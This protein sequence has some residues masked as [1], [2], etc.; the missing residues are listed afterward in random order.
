MKMKQPRW[1]VPVKLG[2][3]AGLCFVLLAACGGDSPEL[4][5]K[6]ARDYLAKDDSSAAVI[7]LR[8]ALQKAPNNAEARYLLGTA[9]AARRDPASAVKELRMAL[10]LGYP[11]EQTL[12]ALARALVDD[13]DAKELVAEFGGKTLGTP[14]AQADFKTI[15]GNAWLSLG[16]P[17]EAEAAFAAALAAKPD[18]PD[19]S[20]GI[21]TLRAASRNFEEADKIVDG[22][23]AQPKAP[24]EASLLKAELLFAEG[25]PDA[26]RAVLEKL[27]E[28]RPAY[29]PA[30]YRLA[31]LQVA[32][33]DLDQASAQVAAI[34]KTSKQDTRAYYFEALVASK[35][36]NL[37]AA[38]EA[39]QQVLKGSPQHVPSLVLAGEIELRAGQFNQAEDYLRRALNAAPGLLYAERLLAA[40]YVRM[41]SP[42]RALEVLQPQLA[43]GYR[44]PQ[45]MAVA[46]EAYLSVGDFPKAAQYFAQTAAL[47]PKNAAARTRLGQVRFAEGDTEAAI[48]DLEAA[49]ALDPNVSSAD[50]ALLSNLLR[51]KQFDEA[52]A[53]V[54]RLEKKQ[55]NNP[56]VYNLKGIVYLSKRDLGSAR[57][58][59]E[60]ALQIQSDYL[61]A[62]GN[63]AQL[64]RLD[65]K[66]DVA[67]KR[68][69]VILEKEPKNEQA[70]LGY[71]GL[72][73]SLGGEASE[74]ETLLKKAVTV[75]PQSIGARIALVAFY[76][77]KGD[78]KQAQFAAQEANAALPNDA[79]TLEL[80]GQVQLASGD[81]AQAVNT[82][83][84]LVAARPGSVEPLLRLARA[85]VAAK[86]YDKAVEKLRAA[87]VINPELF[88]ASREIVVIYALTGRPEQALQEV[89]A[90]QRRQ[91]GEARGYLLEGEL[92]GTQQ[93][94]SDAESAIKAAQKRAPDDGTIAVALYAATSGAGKAAAA[95]AA[96][97]KW[98]H[99]HPKDV[100][101]RN[102]LGE[103]AVRK[104]DYKSAARYYQAV[105]AQ[106]PDNAMYLNN[107]AWVLGELGDPK[108]MSHAEKAL[109]LAPENPAILDTMGTLLVKK[110]DVTQGLEKLRLA[111]QRAPNQ[112]DIRLHLA[113]ALIKAGDKQAARKELDALTQASNPA[114]EKPAS[115][116]QQAGKA[117]P[118]T[119]G[120]DCAAEVAALLKTL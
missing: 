4:L 55:P 81:A 47:D 63:L 84:K 17:K 80:L 11:A 93:K 53:A 50:L 101:L 90:I 79:R 99:D 13:G 43:R 32:R 75:N 111:A 57:A 107:L 7:Q 110:G 40:T 52:L 27:V 23:L 46:G 51:Q 120:A 18:F 116:P 8:N 16:K 85:L 76:T 104:Q 2:V 19:A 30:R 66:P 61:P 24:P 12:P 45:L 56:L 22:V 114:A 78:L 39:I 71:A 1:N 74:I 105:V 25:Q 14:D 54:G 62:I 3:V 58:S 88:E 21:A 118:L 103:R 113:K 60:R 59:F 44:D 94:W 91:P 108:A 5:I 31:A 82:F 69:E 35:K 102:Y 112:S 41:G 86:D 15:I 119:C 92:L 100:V 9:L 98:L 72:V 64:D 38:R 117:P 97:D 6:S 48:R 33:G 28:A 68:Y 65:K 115:A 10:Q 49:S 37:P 96:A 34:R 89:K 106:Q 109:A 70:L 29:L 73:Q 87:L 95:D 20:L 36:G 26:S 77:Q 83:N 42:A 67:R